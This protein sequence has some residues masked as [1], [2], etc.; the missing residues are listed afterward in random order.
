MGDEFGPMMALIG[1]QA[2]ACKQK[3]K[4]AF[5]ACSKERVTTAEKM[6]AYVRQDHRRAAQVPAGEGQRDEDARG[7]RMPLGQ[8][9]IA[10][11]PI[12]LG[13][14]TGVHLSSR[15]EARGQLVA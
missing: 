15:A 1:V 2:I 7:K 9:R 6:E 10:R 14:C 5:Y 4:D 12:E 8:R 11:L 13:S 3:E